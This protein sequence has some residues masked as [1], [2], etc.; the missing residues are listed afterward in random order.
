MGILIP[1]LGAKYSQARV[2]LGTFGVPI[3]GNGSGN[4]HMKNRTPVG[5]FLGCTL[6][7]GSYF[8]LN[9]EGRLFDEE[10]IAISAELRL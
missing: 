9:V 1:Y 2:L 7:T 4:L 5:L 8:F 6:T 3:A 10:A